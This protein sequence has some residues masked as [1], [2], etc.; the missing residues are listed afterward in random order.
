MRFATYNVEWF[1]ALF[2]DKWIDKPNRGC[3]SFF[4]F[5]PQGNALDLAMEPRALRKKWG[6]GKEWTKIWCPPDVTG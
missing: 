5:D 3:N 1:N 4:R 2:D 6:K